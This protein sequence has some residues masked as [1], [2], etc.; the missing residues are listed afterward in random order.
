MAQF[1]K[2]SITD[3]ENMIPYELTLM[4]DMLGDHIEKVKKNARTKHR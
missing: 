2:Y 4:M 3:L 1:H